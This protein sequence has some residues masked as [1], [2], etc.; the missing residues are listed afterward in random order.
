MVMVLSVDTEEDNWVP[1][2]KGVSVSNVVDAIPDFADRLAGLGIRP[3]YF[4]SYQVAKDRAAAAA[5]REALARAGGEI[6]AHVHPWNTPPY[7]GVEDEITMLCSYPATAQ[8]DKIESVLEEIR[9]SFGA[10]PTAFRAGRFG[11]G[12]V[13]LR[14]LTETGI[15]VDSSVTPLLNWRHA[16]GPSFLDAENRVY[17]VGDDQNVCHPSVS[18]DLLELPITVGYTRLS[19]PSWNALARQMDSKA[20]RRLRLP[21]VARRLVGLEKVILSPEAESSA[22]MI[23]LG[24]HLIR[25]GVPFLHMFLHSSSLVPGLTPF[26][27]TAGEVE[28]V[29]DRIAAFVNAMTSVA[30]LQFMTVTEA[31]TALA[32]STDLD[33][34]DLPSDG[35]VVGSGTP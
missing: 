19:P 3:S 11:I 1:A 8:R 2:R 5:L 24:R 21:A 30:D 15:R 6:G 33:F 20:A 29:H 23:R 28:R 10:V 13:A 31:A 22:D 27:R 16:E 25:H 4:T 18:S 32:E 14:A 12:R 7:C 35:D 9:H 34:A 17:R 26:T